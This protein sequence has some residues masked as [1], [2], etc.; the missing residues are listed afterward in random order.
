MATDT[1]TEPKYSTALCK[2][3]GMVPETLTLLQE[4]E[5]G[6]STPELYKSVLESGAIP[7]ATAGRVKDIVSRVFAP[8]YLAD[9]ARPAKRLKKLL[10]TGYGPDDLSQLFLIY[11]A[12]T[13]P[14]LRDFI[15]EIY[16]GR[17]AAGAEYLYR[18]DS[19]VFFRNAYESGKLPNKWTDGSRAKIARYLLGALTDFKLVGPA[20]KD[21]RQILSFGIREFTTLYLVHDL[22]FAGVGDQ[23]L[24][25]HPD[26]QLFG[27]EPYDVLQEL[28]AV[29][30]RG[31]FVVQHSGQILRIA[32][33]FNTMEEFLDAA[34]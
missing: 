27:L 31:Q 21:H 2:G 25:A 6:M 12:R 14:E 20:V 3:Q 30:G 17:Y 4:W 19:D 23:S 24:L 18:Q 13:Y 26:W 5:P 33:G 16:W 1:D 7:K 34:A 15:V 11:C 10:E 32:W 28:R 29:A 9:D 8:R 22:H